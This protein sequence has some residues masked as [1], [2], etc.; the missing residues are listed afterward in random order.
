MVRFAADI[1]LSRG[2]LRC[3]CSLCARLRWWA[4]LVTPAAFRLLSGAEALGDYQ[5][6]T[7]REHHFFCRQC[8][9][10]AFATGTSPERGPFY[11]VNLACLTDAPPEQL[12][13]APVTWVDGKNDDWDHAPAVTAHL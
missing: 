6:H 11:A 3:N 1:D 12:G 5:F 9:I 4:A 7:R 13:A 10:H 8:G 2:T